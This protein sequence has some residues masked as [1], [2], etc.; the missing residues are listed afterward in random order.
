MGC[1]I[2]ATSEPTF[3]ELETERAAFSS[4]GFVYSNIFTNIFENFIPVGNN[5]VA[6]LPK[7]LNVKRAVFI[8]AGKQAL[9]EISTRL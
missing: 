1:V 5:I 6:L 7:Y 9:V 3:G 8:C 4:L 2:A